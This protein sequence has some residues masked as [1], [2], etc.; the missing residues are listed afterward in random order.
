MSVESKHDLRV[1]ELKAK[2][3]EEKRRLKEAKKE[4]EYVQ[5]VEYT[6]KETSEKTSKKKSKKRSRDEV[7]SEEKQKDEQNERRNNDK[8]EEDGVSEKKSRKKRKSVSFADN[9]DVQTIEHKDEM[10]GAGTETKTDDH[11]D[12]ID[13]DNEEQNRERRK[14]EKREKREQRRKNSEKTATTTKGDKS[15]TESA[16]KTIIAYLWQYHHDRTSWKFQKIREAQLLKHVFSLEHVPS[17]YNPALLAYLKGLKSEGARTRLRKSAQDVIKFDEKHTSALSADESTVTEE[18]SDIAQIPVLPESWR[19]EYGNAVW[20]FKGNLNAGVKDLNEGVTL[21]APDGDNNENGEIDPNVLTRLEH[22]K[23]AEMVL[24]TASGKIG[25]F[26]S[27]T[28]KPEKSA[29]AE[30]E[31]EPTETTSVTKKET[32]QKA[33]ARKKRKNRTMIV[34]ISSSSESSD[35]D[36]D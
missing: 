14:K 19:E 26:S 5:D 21:T 24:W 8:I 25:K 6:V 23:R 35:S 27:A 33:P 3:K 36:S 1:S 11:D 7:D 34:D 16:D 9:V 32:K 20:R 17:E 12:K 4:K 15:M 28:S 30:A 29:E 13:A 2:K 22:R 10:N 31:S 18:T